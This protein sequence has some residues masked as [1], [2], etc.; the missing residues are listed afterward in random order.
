MHDRRRTTGERRGHEQVLGAG[1]AR[2]VHVDVG[3]FEA[4]GA[5]FIVTIADE[6]FGAHALEPTHVN[7]NWPRAEPAAAGSRCRHLPLTC[8]DWPG[9][10]EGGTHAADEVGW[11]LMAADLAGV[12]AHTVL[13]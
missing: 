1:M 13:A 9:D 3:A 10:E 4:A 7:V 6:D 12:D 2:G 5:H 8:Q 11:S